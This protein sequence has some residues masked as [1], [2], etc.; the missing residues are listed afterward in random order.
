MK[1]LIILSLALIASLNQ[2]FA[3]ATNGTSNVKIVPVMTIT[4]V[5]PLE[6]GSVATV[7]SSAGTVVLTAAASTTATPTNVTLLSTGATRSAGSF[8]INGES[9][10][11]YTLSALPASITL[12][13]GANTMTVNGLTSSANRTLTAGTD[14]LFIGGTLNVT[15]NQTPGSYTGTYPVTVNY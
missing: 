12:T 6:F 5:N 1:K 3:A 4:A 13:S 11:T 2:A 7:G 15:A 8:T 9:G 14:T 10:S